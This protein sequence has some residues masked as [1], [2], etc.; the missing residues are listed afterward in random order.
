MRPAS[1]KEKIRDGFNKISGG[2]VF[3]G[4]RRTLFNKQAEIKTQTAPECAYAAVSPLELL[5]T[6]TALGYSARVHEAR[7]QRLA[8][9]R[10]RPR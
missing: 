1:A 4:N 8:S 6:A 7:G 3:F 2:P 9:Q 10:R 5:A